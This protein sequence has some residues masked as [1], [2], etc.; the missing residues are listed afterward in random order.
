MVFVAC[1]EFFKLLVVE[2]ERFPRN[3]SNNYFFILSRRMKA[4]GELKKTSLSHS[5]CGTRNLIS[6][7]RCVIYI[8]RLLDEAEKKSKVFCCCC[9]WLLTF[10]YNMVIIISS[11]SAFALTSPS[12]SRFIFTRF[13]GTVASSNLYLFFFH[14]WSITSKPI[15]P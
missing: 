14:I 4:E 11:L 7:T 1:E 10:P 2:N 12:F 15:W 9:W 13:L 6:N 3:R 8:L 5:S